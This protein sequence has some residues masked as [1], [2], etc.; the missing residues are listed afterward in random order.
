[1][2]H[3]NQLDKKLEVFSILGFGG[4]GKTT[5]AVEVCRR[6]EE[7][8]SCQATVTV[9]QAFDASKDMSGLLLRILHQVVKVKR[10][11][12]QNCMQ[13]EDPLGEIDS[14]VDNLA[15]MLIQRLADKRYLIVIDDVWTISAWDAIR[16][17]LLDNNNSSRII[18]TT[19]IETVAKA[20]TLANAWGDHIYRVKPLKL[21]DSKT[22]F[23]NRV[24]GP[25]NVCPNDL[26]TAMDGIL[27]K[28]AGLPLA[29]VSIASLL[30]SY[31]TPGSL[32]MWTRICNSI[33][34]QMESNPTLEG[35]RQSIT[36]SY[37]HLPHHLKA[38]MMYL[39]IFPE[40]YVTSKD[41]LLN[42]WIAEGLIPEKRGLTLEEVAESYY[43]EL[44]S[45]NMIQPGQVIYDG[46]AIEC[47]VHDM[48]L[49][50]IVSKALEVNFVSL[51]G[52]R[53]GGSSHDTVRR[54]SIHG[55]LGSNIEETSMR[56]V[57]SLSTFRPEGQGK[58]LDRLAEFTLLRVLDLQDCKD[59]KDHHMKHVC[60][61]FFLRFLNLNHTD[62]TLLPSQIG[63]LQHLQTLW[64]YGT[65]LNGVPE[66]V[67]NLEKLE[68]FGLS[69]RKDWRVLLRLPRGLGKMKALE[70]LLRVD[71]REG[72]TE[73][74]KEMGDM[75]QLRRL[76]IV[77]RC[78][79]CSDKPVL[80]EIG[81]SIGRISSI[82][83]ISVEDMS[84]DANNMDFLHHLPSPPLLLRH[85]T[86]GGKINGFPDWMASL[87]HLV[88][89]ELWWIDM[90][91]DDIYG[92]LYK[93]P[94][95]LKITL[96]RK[97]C[98]DEELVARTTFKFPV[99]KELAIV[100]DNST[101]RVVRFEQGA[102]GKLEKLMV[103]FCDQER[104]LAGIDNLTSL[105]EVELV[106]KKNTKALQVAADQLK[107][108]SQSRQEAEQFKVVLKYE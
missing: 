72:D 92:V 43:D 85:I 106:G 12:E 103:R 91:G 68:Y 95:L 49:E 44:F 50:V 52:S 93:L 51:I 69:N 2:T 18:V 8:F 70:G 3:E 20:C 71:I 31:K 53:Y 62:I 79:G 45:R 36:L 107:T 17:K 57:R 101:P 58:L 29:I 63:E 99:L 94:N 54:L 40:D 60:R 35:M 23:V 46:S 61:L 59:V 105:Q 100:R 75:V 104:S 42:R 90:H 25:N 32:E 37:N 6:L 56:H 65:L 26:E 15:S 77:L 5:L 16:C 13:E 102:M 28:S 67:I 108:E 4:L 33:G 39:S 11:N 97:C 14:N 19:R 76:G 82:R 48:M 41:R 24:F 78:T 80:R 22:L 96:D 89:I 84:E 86:V 74:A 9:L 10:D 30:A 47:R 73:L 66:S 88:H 55:D 7:E 81:N 64:L 27:K 83:Q 38:C 1:M 21:E 98:K 87:T 34:S